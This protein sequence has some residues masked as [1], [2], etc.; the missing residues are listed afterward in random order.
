MAVARGYFFLMDKTLSH[1]SNWEASAKGPG[2]PTSSL[3]TPG[4]LRAQ[5]C[6]RV[7]HFPLG[8]SWTAASSCKCFLPSSLLWGLIKSR[9]Q[10]PNQPPEGSRG[11]RRTSEL[12][13]TL[14]EFY[15][16]L[17][18]PRRGLSDSAS[19]RILREMWLVPQGWL[20]K[21]KVICQL[22]IKGFEVC[23]P[24]N[25]AGVSLTD[26]LE[27]KES[28]HRWGTFCAHKLLLVPWLSITL[29]II[30]YTKRSVL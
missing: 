26:P 24:P 2:F 23:S 13:E 14:C 28:R 15:Y 11:T 7:T 29:S 22:P 17:N 27:G 12:P 8:S 18:T 19:R 25:P 16:T 6:W 20:E 30:K 4:N 1:V 3:E 10:V 21:D 5:Q 9:G